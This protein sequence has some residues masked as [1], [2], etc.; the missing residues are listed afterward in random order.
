MF[1][2]WGESCRNVDMSSPPE[3]KLRGRQHAA[4]TIEDPLSL[5]Y[6]QLVLCMR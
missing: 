6:F 1:G 4:P 5:L 3:T 2:F